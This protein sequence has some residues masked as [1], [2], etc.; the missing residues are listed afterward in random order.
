MTD[1]YLRKRIL[2]YPGKLMPVA[3]NFT[4]LLIALTLLT[5]CSDSIETITPKKIPR[6]AHLVGTSMSELVT[7][8]TPSTRTGTLLALRQ[9]NIFNQE[10]GKITAVPYYPGDSFKKNMPLVSLDGSL[11]N[12]QFDKAS[13]TR[14]QAVLDLKRTTSL[15]KKRLAAEDERARI[16]T[17]LK[18]AEAEEQ[19]LKTRLNYTTIR[20]P[21][22]GIVSERLIEPGDIA[23]R[24]SH[25]L[26]IIDQN[27]IIARV[28]VSELLLPLFKENDP[29]S[30]TIDA[31][32]NHV[33]EGKIS[34]IF[35]TINPSTRLGTVEVSFKKIPSGAR[36]GAFVRVTLE[37]P[38]QQ[39]LLIPFTGL[40][41][42]NKG[43]FIYTINKKQKAIKKY[44]TTGI[45]HENMISITQGIKENTPVII[46]GFLGLKPGK[47]VTTSL[48]KK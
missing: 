19:L 33:Y 10:E 4:C 30:I 27:S 32:G 17:S 2:H 29:A 7:L 18:I 9:V 25:L 39:H 41:R 44:V 35:P 23:P 5:S 45:R 46:Q 16:A 15:V 31:L 42:D 1:T 11:L 47:A 40:R 26:T 3:K 24:H 12:A 34:R 14:K 36:A 21:F 22:S 20:A 37:P 6:A 13:A 48:E 28:S 38:A 8:N 43:E